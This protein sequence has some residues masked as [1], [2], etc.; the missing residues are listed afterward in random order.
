[1]SISEYLTQI[2]TFC[3]LLGI[4]GYTVSEAEQILTILSG[5]SKDY[6][7]V[8]TVL[9]SKKTLPNLQYVHSTLLAHKV[10]LS[11]EGQLTQISLPTL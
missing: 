11:K 10:E 9:A 4:A 1:M 8:V 3:D 6:E 7:L 2:K 5:L